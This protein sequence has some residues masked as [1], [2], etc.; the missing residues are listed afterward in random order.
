MKIGQKVRVKGTSFNGRTGVITGFHTGVIPVGV[1]LDGEKHE[2]DFA[3]K[4]LESICK[5]CEKVFPVEE[6][7]CGFCKECLEE[8]GHIAKQDEKFYEMAYGVPTAD[9]KRC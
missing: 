1:T 6:L 5:E 4:E 7:N 3:E 2:T 8:E 9:E